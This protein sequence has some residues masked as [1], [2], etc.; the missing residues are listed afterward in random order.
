MPQIKLS[1]K[2]FKKERLNYS[3]WKLAFWR[4][5][6]QN[7]VDAKSSSIKILTIPVSDN[8]CLV[9]FKD[10]GCGMSRETLES[11]YFALGESNKDNGDT[12]GGFGKARALTC[13]G[14]ESYKLRTHNLVVNGSGSEYT[15]EHDIVYQEGVELTIHISGASADKL[16]R[17]LVDYLSESNLSHIDVFVNEMRWTKWFCPRTH[18]RDIKCGKVFTRSTEKEEKNFLAVRVSGTLMYSYPISAN[19][20]VA[21]EVSPELSRSVLTSNRDGMTY[22]YSKELQDFLN[23]ISIDKLSA[24]KPKFNFKSKKHKGRG[25]YYRPYVKNKSQL[26]NCHEFKPIPDD[27]LLSLTADL[28]AE[29]IKKFLTTFAPTVTPSIAGRSFENLAIFP[30]IYIDDETE[31]PLVRRVI[32]KYAPENWA[33]TTI[34]G[35]TFLSGGNRYRLFLTW[36]TI[37]NYALDAL[38]EQTKFNVDSYGC[39][40]KFSDSVEASFNIVDGD[41]FFLLNPVDKNGKMIYS[42]NDRSD[43]H[44]LMCL[45]AHEAAHV[46]F[47]MHDEQYASLLTDLCWRIFNLEK[48]ILSEIRQNLLQVKD[49]AVRM[50]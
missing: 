35:K 27:M 21:V 25:L 9:E 22:E 44:K 41:N 3:D 11:V 40:W 1:P 39:G 29:P 34:D 7:S 37:V 2:F 50:A 10:N 19:S 18:A 48:K 13:F 47:S 36:K 30:D 17:V 26:E 38:Y 32:D 45:A 33:T 31:N 20:Q 6:F 5:L 16:N 24:L 8:S 4:E 28:K 14:M 49:V 46:V 12:I 42:V 23:E 43:I 15:I